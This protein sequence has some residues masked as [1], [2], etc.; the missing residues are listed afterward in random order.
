MSGPIARFLGNKTNVTPNQVTYMRIPL[1]MFTFYHFS[2]GEFVNLTIGAIGIILWELLDH[3]DGDL[4]TVRNMKSQKGVWL[5]IVS[6][7]V[8]GTVNGFLGLF[9]TIGIYRQMGGW[10]PWLIFSLV[11]IGYQ[12]FKILLHVETPKSKGHSLKEE[13][14]DI[15]DNSILGKIAHFFYYWVEMFI[16]IAV[17]LYVPF[18]EYFHL[19]TLFLAMIGFAVLYN[20][21]WILIIFRQYKRFTEIK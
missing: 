1:A 16:I 2:V 6:D 3:V 9:I 15:K 21:F 5:E 20:V 11:S 8:F 7:N 14:E 17:I 10:L 19:N 13:F 12:L 4:A 18:M